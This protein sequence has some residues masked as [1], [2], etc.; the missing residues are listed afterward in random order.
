MRFICPISGIRFYRIS[1]DDGLDLAVP[2]VTSILADDEPKENR[3]RLEQWK[4]REIAAGRDPDAGRIRGSAVHAVLEDHIRGIREA[5]ESQEVAAYASGMERHLEDYDKFL[6]SERPLVK[7]WEHCWSERDEKNERL[8]RV[9]SA[10]WGAAGTPDL[11]ARDRRGLISLDDFKSAAK[12]Y[13]R[14]S[15]SPVPLHLMN[16]WLKYK[17]TVRQ[18]CAYKLMAEETLGIEIDRLRIIVGL[19][20]EGKSQLFT[21]NRCEI[22]AETEAFKRM[23]VAFWQRQAR[24]NAAGL[25][26]AAAGAAA[27]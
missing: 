4:Q 5:P 16:S 27:A 11:I 3:E 23:C 21:L 19:P 7:G 18:L 24:R 8:A 10:I 12:P 26:A 22:A 15:G 17:R 1:T 2:G 13:F 9:W 14:C 20:E 6:W 25:E